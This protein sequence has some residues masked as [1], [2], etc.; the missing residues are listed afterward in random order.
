[1]PKSTKHGTNTSKK[2]LLFHVVLFIFLCDDDTGTINY[3][4]ACRLAEL[5]QRA[6]VS[7]VLSDTY[8]STTAQQRGQWGS[9][10]RVKEES[11]RTCVWRGSWLKAQRHNDQDDGLQGGVEVEEP[12]RQGMTCARVAGS[13]ILKFVFTAFTLRCAQRLL[14]EHIID[15]LMQTT[16]DSSITRAPMF[17]VA[18]KCIFNLLDVVVRL[19]NRLRQLCRTRFR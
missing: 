18:P 17:E 15:K 10:R 6:S 4:Q 11:G 14:S 2:M 7:C 8:F 3:V 16:T 13:F 5:T 19:C 9:L 12:E 1:M